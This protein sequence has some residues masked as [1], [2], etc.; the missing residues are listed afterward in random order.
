MLELVTCFKNKYCFVKFLF[1]F[2]LSMYML[3]CYQVNVFLT[4]GHGQKQ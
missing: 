3:L 4:L 2:Y 1:Q